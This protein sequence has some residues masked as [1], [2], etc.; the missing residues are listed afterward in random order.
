MKN[1]FVLIFCL[2]CT[3]GHAEV[4][5][6]DSFPDLT[7]FKLEGILPAELKGKIVLVDFW[8]SWCGPCKQSFPTMNELNKK[9]SGRGVII[10]AVNEDEK[11]SKMD[12]F[13][14]SNKISFNVV[15]DAAP[16]GS[17]LVDKIAIAGMPSSFIL[18]GEGKVRFVHIGFLG[19]ETKKKYEQ[20]IEFLLK[21]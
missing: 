7:T 8:A 2:I 19:S 3:I 12:D 4:K 17:K 6:G 11:R 15:R 10:I 18:D 14:K 21:K 20:E 16:E 5:P 13:L 1:S 9:Y